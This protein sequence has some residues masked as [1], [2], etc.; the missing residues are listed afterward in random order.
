[1]SKEF[2]E[3]RRNLS[4]LE[5][6]KRTRL[7]FGELMDA[8]RHYSSPFE[9]GIFRTISV[10]AGNQGKP[11]LEWV[12]GTRFPPLDDLPD[13]FAKLHYAGGQLDALPSSFWTTLM[14]SDREVQLA[15]P[16]IP[17]Q[18][19]LWGTVNKDQ[20]RFVK[21]ANMYYRFLKDFN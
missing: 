1:M 4:T 18:I 15:L 13:H 10:R 11:Q 7:Y 14:D 21:V 2:G 19:T 9:P 6:L 16:Y 3:F 17:M 12:S 8:L 20:A 5:G